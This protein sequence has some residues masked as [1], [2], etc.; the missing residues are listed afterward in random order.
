MPRRSQLA[1][2]QALDED[3]VKDEQIVR[4]REIAGS[5]RD[6]SAV[7][8][9]GAVEEIDFLKDYFE[10]LLSCPHANPKF[11]SETQMPGMQFSAVA[12]KRPIAIAHRMIAAP[13]CIHFLCFSRVYGAN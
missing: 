12:L 9:D 10:A 2:V 8:P 3:D 1:N 6:G 5:R 11:L 13:D 4:K 7:S